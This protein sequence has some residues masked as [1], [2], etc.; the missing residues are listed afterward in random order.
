LRSDFAAMIGQALKAEETGARGRAILIEKLT[1]AGLDAIG[2]EL[3]VQRLASETDAAFRVRLIAAN[4]IGEL[5]LHKTLRSVAETMVS[6]L[7]QS[8][9]VAAILSSLAADYGIG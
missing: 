8:D 5:P 4:E 7:V 1:G 9:P 2:A 3:Q 6:E